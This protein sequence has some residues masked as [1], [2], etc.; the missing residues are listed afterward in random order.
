[1]TTESLRRAANLIGALT[2]LVAGCGAAPTGSVPSAGSA[3]PVGRIAPYPGWT[4]LARLQ[5]DDVGANGEAIAAGDRETSSRFLLVSAVCTTGNLAITAPGPVDPS[6]SS[7]Q[8]PVLADPQR[9]MAFVGDDLASWAVRVV[10][11]RTIDFEVL[12]E[13]SDVPLHIPAIVLTAGDKTIEMQGGCGGISLSWGYVASDQCGTTIP[14]EPIE[15]IQMERGA[16]ATVAIDGWTISRADALCGRLER[17]GGNPDLFEAMPACTVQAT[18][19]GGEVR[20]QGLKPSPDPWL[21]ELGMAAEAAWGDQF[22]GP[23]Y[24]YVSVP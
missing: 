21:V 4:E 23:F 1:M 5:P 18:L 13:G 6:E 8:C 22:S 7:V 3:E 15:T 16:T 11:T 14:E 19:D 10:P 2:L 24:A 17:A 12:I 20:L 9:S